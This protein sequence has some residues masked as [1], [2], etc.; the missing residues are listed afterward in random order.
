MLVSLNNLDACDFLHARGHSSYMCAGLQRD[1]AAFCADA[2]ASQRFATVR[3]SF[4]QATEIDALLLGLG[5]CLGQ[6]LVDFA[7]QLKNYILSDTLLLVVDCVTA[8]EKD[9]A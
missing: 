4:N 5:G 6:R 1:R 2:Q 3:N 9:L 7:Q 8:S